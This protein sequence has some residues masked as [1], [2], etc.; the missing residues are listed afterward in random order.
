MHGRRWVLSWLRCCAYRFLSLKR[1]RGYIVECKGVEI[2][3]IG[4]QRQFFSFEDKRHL[5][6]GKN[7]TSK[8]ERTNA[9]HAAEHRLPL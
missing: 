7:Q 9:L 1:V 4:K 6:P 2:F 3:P 8:N 5:I